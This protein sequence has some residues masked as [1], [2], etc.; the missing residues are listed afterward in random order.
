MSDRTIDPMDWMEDEDRFAAEEAE[1]IAE[2]EAETQRDI[3]WMVSRC[4][5]EDCL[6]EG[7]E[8][9]RDEFLCPDHYQAAF[10]A[11]YERQREVQDDG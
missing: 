2:E 4:I 6:E 1:R 9:L 3:A 5:R 8:R 7:S 11:E 10:D